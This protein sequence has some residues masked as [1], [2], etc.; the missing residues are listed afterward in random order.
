MSQDQEAA[1]VEE[2]K[3]SKR[4]SDAVVTQR[5]NSIYQLLRNGVRKREE[6]LRSIANAQKRE[7]E[8][9]KKAGTDAARIARVQITW[10]Q[11]RIPNRT[12]DYY[13]HKAKIQLDEEGRAVPRQGDFIL[14]VQMAR[15]NDLYARAYA[16][17]KLTVCARLIEE[18]NSMFGLKTINL[19]LST[20]AQSDSG[21]E[22]PEAELT[23]E[24]FID[25]FTR[26]KNLI[27]ERGGFKLA[28]AEH[29]EIEIKRLGNGNGA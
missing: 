18:T 10:G 6:I 3:R 9:L 25:E 14:G 20:A 4:M 26:Y 28:R 29:Q 23:E 1:P 21:A 2:K 17:G 16:A 12:V 7:A 11:D 15:I 13:I 22:L 24:Q 19:Q 27:E 5:V 8:E